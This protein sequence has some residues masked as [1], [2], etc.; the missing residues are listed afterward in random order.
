[1]QIPRL[2][3]A[4]CRHLNGEILLSQRN[5]H[6]LANVLRAKPNQNLTV[7]DGSGY[8]FD[9]YVVSIVK[10][11]ST[12]FLTQGRNCCDNRLPVSLGIA[13]IKSSRFDWALQ[14]ATELGVTAIQPLLTQFTNSP[15]S[16][17][18]LAKKELHWRE[19]LINACEQSYNSWLPQLL[20]VKKIEELTFHRQQVIMAQPASQKVTINSQ[21]HT[22]LLIGPEGGF[23]NS[24]VKSLLKKKV[25]PMSLGPRILRTETAA[26]AGI[27]M[28]SQF[29]CQYAERHFD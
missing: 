4:N 1:M 13:V 15:P 24:E 12:I 9:A 20:N 16:G 11:K 2:F 26:I 22:M 3:V 28:L 23:S 14:K 25:Q 18:Y 10:K 8:E 5:H 21:K 6:Y 27:A 17:E 29:Y 7:F 19:I